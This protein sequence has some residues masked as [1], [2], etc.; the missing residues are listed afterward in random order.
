MFSSIAV[1]SKIMKLSQF[2]VFV[3]TFICSYLPR[4]FLKKLREIWVNVFVWT[5]TA[6]VENAV[7]PASI[8]CSFPHDCLS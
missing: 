7:L 3:V 6:V 5:Q 4:I 2:F 1:K 8:V